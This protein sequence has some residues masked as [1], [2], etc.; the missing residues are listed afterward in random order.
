MKKFIF[1]ALLFMLPVIVIFVFT[2]YLIRQVPNDFTFKNNYLEKYSKEI[3]ILT[4][5]NSH[6]FSGINPVY[7]AQKAFNLAYGSQTLYFDHGIF[8]KYQHRFDSLKII[9]LSISYGSLLE[10]LEEGAEINQPKNYAIYYGINAKSLKNKSELLF[11]PFSI[12]R[13]IR[14]KNYY[15]HVDS[16]GFRIVTDYSQDLQESGLGAADYTQMLYSEN[17]IKYFD[18]NLKLINSFIKYCDQRKIKLVFFTA[19]TF[20]SYRENTDPELLNNMVDTINGFVNQYSH[21][22]YLNYFED[23]GFDSNDYYDADHLNAKGAEKLTKKVIHALDS[24]GF[25][26]SNMN[27]QFP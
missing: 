2:E 22:F 25:L 9:L 13:L 23:P 4:F 12:G 21:C 6:A 17:R 11:N 14:K 15:R 16:L 19:P 3:Q 18:E 20:S 27:K 7:F 5:G 24:L 1:K 8:S 10:K 26:K